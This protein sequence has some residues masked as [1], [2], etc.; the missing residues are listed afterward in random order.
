[1]VDLDLSIFFDR[2]NHDRL[3]ARLATRVNDKRVLKLIRS[4]FTA[5]VMIGAL[6]QP[7][8]EGTP[9]GGLLSLL[10]SNIVL[11]ELDKE[12]EKRALRFVRY[13]DDCV[14]FVNSKGVANRVMQSISRTV[15]SG[16]VCCVVLEG[17]VVRLPPIPI[18]GKAIA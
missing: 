12:L 4:F 3:M 11:D 1:V 6:E 16:P 2:V 10:L 17:V 15:Q 8:Q 13:P 5:G 9:Q 14:I 18:C 7:T